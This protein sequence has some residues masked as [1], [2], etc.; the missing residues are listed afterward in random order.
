MA[1]GNPRGRVPRKTII[2][3]NVDANINLKRARAFWAVSLILIGALF[4]ALGAIGTADVDS[5][6]AAAAA[7]APF[8]AAPA[9]SASSD[10]SQVK[11]YFLNFAGD[12]SLDVATVVEQVVSG[13]ASYTVQL[14][15]AS[16]AEQSVVVAAP[17]GGLQVEMH[18]MTGDH[19]P[20]DVVLRPALLCWPPTVLV[21]D[22][23]DHFAV[24]VSGAVPGS[25]SSR[26]NLGSR[27]R[28]AQTFAL[29]RTSGLKAVYLP[30]SKRVL[31]PQLQQNLLSSFPEALAKDSRRASSPGRAPPFSIT[32]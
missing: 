15:L 21:N 29:L 3:M 2:S 7:N 5:S 16:G 1:V 22:G 4:C 28:D 9:F 25:F 24:V 26:E 13:Y 6:R 30:H 19:V 31:A 10:H 17:P 11:N 23:H 27:R 32:I 20:N 14:H 18:D 12:H 8:A